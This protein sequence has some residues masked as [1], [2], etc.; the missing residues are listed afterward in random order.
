MRLVEI[1][2]S[3]SKILPVAH[4]GG[5][6]PR[7]KPPPSRVRPERLMWAPMGAALLILHLLAFPF[8]RPGTVAYLGGQQSSSSPSVRVPGGAGVPGE[9]LP[10][11]K[12][13]NYKETK[14][15]GWVCSWWNNRSFPR[16]NGTIKND[17][18]VLNK[19]T[20]RTRS[21][22]YWNGQ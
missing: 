22:K 2:V 6:C 20:L 17:P 5:A 10:P 18:I 14:K 21:K 12:I 8:L 19:Q 1:F 15:Q 13:Q 3:G 4:E 9:A 11:W 16:T 7:P